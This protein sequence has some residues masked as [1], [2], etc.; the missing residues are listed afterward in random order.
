MDQQEFVRRLCEAVSDATD[1]NFPCFCHERMLPLETFN[2][3]D[4]A[5]AEK[6]LE[7]IETFADEIKYA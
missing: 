5:K 6:I 2:A 7:L 1:N 3:P 4:R